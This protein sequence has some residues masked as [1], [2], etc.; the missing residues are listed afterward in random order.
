MGV[1]LRASHQLHTVIS[2][3]LSHSW[4]PLSAA[5]G[6]HDPSEPLELQP[7]PWVRGVKSTLAHCVNGLFGI[8]GACLEGERH[9]GDIRGS[10]G[11]WLTCTG[12]RS[13]I[14]QFI[15]RGST[16]G[17]APAVPSRRSGTSQP[18]QATKAMVSPR[19][20][21]QGR[22]KAAH[23]EG[24]ERALSGTVGWALGRG[25]PLG[26]QPQHLHSLQFHLGVSRSDVGAGIMLCL[27]NC[28]SAAPSAPPCH[29]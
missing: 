28:S 7:H 2:S 4:A 20:S 23:R 22:Q 8:A 3:S 10:M 15:N 26:W 24:E 1:S 19:L 21:R 17:A 16:G 11:T 13:S 5:L 12:E 14:W 6:G 27:T 25:T 18:R 9:G 29:E